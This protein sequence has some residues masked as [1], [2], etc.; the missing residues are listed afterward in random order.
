MLVVSVLQLL[1]GAQ[2]SKPLRHK[3][4]LAHTHCRPPGEALLPQTSTAR[5]S[6]LARLMVRQEGRAGGRLA[7][8]EHEKRKSETTTLAQG[9]QA[10]RTLSA[11]SKRQCDLIGLEPR[12]GRAAFRRVAANSSRDL[13]LWLRCDA[14]AAAAA[15]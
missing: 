2:F 5:A 8:A 3:G 12:S 6:S 1:G 10:A 4:K 14:A 9:V 13:Q 11:S 7:E 15:P